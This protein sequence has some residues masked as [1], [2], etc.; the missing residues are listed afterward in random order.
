MTNTDELLERVK[1]QFSEQDS[2]DL[3]SGD[4]VYIEAADVAS[5]I[6]EIERLQAQVPVWGG[7]R[8]LCEHIKTGSR[9]T[10]FESAMNHTN[11]KH[12]GEA[13]LVYAR[14][15]DPKVLFVREQNEFWRKFT[16]VKSQPPEDTHG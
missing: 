14:V 15:S 3:S 16:I 12:D 10:V 1:Q 2:G 7:S 13:F 11:G 4:T 5:L 8:Y 6:A 9:Y